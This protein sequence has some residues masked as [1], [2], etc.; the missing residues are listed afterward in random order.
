MEKLVKLIAGKAAI[1]EAQAQMAVEV[2]IV[3]FKERMNDALEIKIQEALTG[4][5][6]E[7]FMDKLGDF[8][9]NTKEKLETLGDAAREK[10]GEFAKTASGFL[11]NTLSNLTAKKEEKK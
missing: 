7:G 10:I 3:Y 8:A 6:E 5:P 2:M 4:E 11:K 9:E 1:T